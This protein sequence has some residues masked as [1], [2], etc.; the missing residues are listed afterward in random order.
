MSNTA[1]G[2]IMDFVLL[3]GLGVTIFYTFKLSRSL[4]NFKKY[5]EE[6]G[7]VIQELGQYIGDAQGAIDKLKQATQI[8]GE[9]LDHRIKDATLLADELQLVNEAGNSLA[10]RLEGLAEKNRKLVQGGQDSFES[11]GVPSN[12]EGVN[13][14]GAQGFDGF[15]IQDRD[16]GAA[17]DVDDEFEDD[18]D[19][20]DAGEFQSQAEKEL[21]D[22]LQS[23]KTSGRGA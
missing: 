2:L 8:S 20:G 13:S 12:F 3:V 15:M 1:F 7:Q 14:N 11:H 16:Y 19:Y 5:R 9:E 4:D 6:F 18:G 21:Y 10:S 23:K 22:A 17:D